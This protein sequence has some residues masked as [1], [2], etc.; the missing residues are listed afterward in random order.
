MKMDP[1]VKIKMSNQ[2]ANTGFIKNGHTTPTWNMR[3]TFKY[4]G[5]SKVDFE[6]FDHDS[7]VVGVED[8]IGS[9]GMLLSPLHGSPERKFR[10]ELHLKRRTK[11]NQLKTAGFILVIIQLSGGGSRYPQQQPSFPQQLSVT[12]CPI[13]GRQQPQIRVGGSSRPQQPGYPQRIQ[14][15]PGGRRIYRGGRYYYQP[16]LQRA[17]YQTRS[18]EDAV[19]N[20]DDAALNEGYDDVA[21]NDDCADIADKEGYADVAAYEKYLAGHKK[22]SGKAGHGKDSDDESARVGG[23]QGSAGVAGH[24]VFAEAFSA[25]KKNK[26]EK[27]GKKKKNKKKKQS[28]SDSDSDSD[29]SRSDSSSSSCK[30]RKKKKKT[31]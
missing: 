5:D 2:I 22:Y 9:V 26:K 17:E 21:F 16:Q 15:Q 11:N 23:H 19:G 12:T 30:S 13:G 27:K 20:P 1:F 10:G 6:V 14:I 25:N 29:S 7:D 3:C 24:Q 8:L 28:S 31:R 4:N 18:P